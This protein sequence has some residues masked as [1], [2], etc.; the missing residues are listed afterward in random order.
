MCTLIGYAIAHYQRLVCS[1][2]RSSTKWRLF[3]V[4]S[5]FWRKLLMQIDNKIPE[6]T[7]GR[8]FI[9]FLDFVEIIEKVMCA[10]T[11]L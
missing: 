6:G 1:G 5:K 3:L 10:H 2:W 11:E 7:K 8:K 9:Q 4:F